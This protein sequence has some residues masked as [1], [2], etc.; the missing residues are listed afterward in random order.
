M[1]QHPPYSARSTIEIP[2]SA[3]RVFDAW[4]DPATAARF[5]AAGSMQVAEAQID[6]REGGAFRIVMRDGANELLHEGRYVVLDRPRRLIFTWIS[7]GTDWRLSLVTVDIFPT[8][9]GSPI[10]LLHEGI[11]D[12]DRA[13]KHRSGWRTILSKLA[14]RFEVD[15]E[16]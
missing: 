13:D 6:A 3:E 1:A 7:A 2:A 9:T 14:E 11:P 4:L 15:I 16:I 10:E 8:P 12:T 5:L